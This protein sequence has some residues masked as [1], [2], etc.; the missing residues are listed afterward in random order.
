MQTTAGSLI[1]CS[2]EDAGNVATEWVRACVYMRGF[3]MK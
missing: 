1:L 3:L 2:D